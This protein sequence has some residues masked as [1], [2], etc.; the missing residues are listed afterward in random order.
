MADE[1]TAD[2]EE[3]RGRLEK[4]RLQ[5]VNTLNSLRDGTLTAKEADALEAAIED[6][7]IALTV[8]PL[9]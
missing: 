6:E 5:L 1:R 2:N 7:I 9:P 3:M 4:A 8:R